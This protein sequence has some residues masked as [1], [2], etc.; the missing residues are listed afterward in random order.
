MKRKFSLLLSLI[1]DP[2][3]ILMD[4]PV[5]GLDSDFQYQFWELVGRLKEYR[6]IVV[7][8][9]EVNPAASIA[10][11][12]LILD[13]GQV[14]QHL[15]FSELN[16]TAEGLIKIKTRV[17]RQFVSESLSAQDCY[18][19]YIVASDDLERV[20]S[21]ISKHPHS[22]VFISTISLEEMILH[23]THTHSS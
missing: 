1:L 3:F 5:S 18:S 19:E 13:E 8:S 7:V 20:E 4:E 15:P 9:H 6:T 21:I 12:C 2:S 17:K 14:V 23:L 10:D 22:H 16:N 11:R